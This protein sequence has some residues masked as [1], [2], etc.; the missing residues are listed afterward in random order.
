MLVKRNLFAT[1][2]GFDPAFTNGFEDVDLCFRAGELGAEVQYCH[3]SCLIHLQSATRAGR[4][5]EESRNCG[6][7]YARWAHRIN[8]DRVRYDAQNIPIALEPNISGTDTQRPVNWLDNHQWRAP[9]VSGACS[10]LSPRGQLSQR[11]AVAP[12]R[13]PPIA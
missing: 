1:L 11:S 3:E 12:R 10:M 6:E 5:E 9:S 4:D 13:A 7:Y 8:P 2:A